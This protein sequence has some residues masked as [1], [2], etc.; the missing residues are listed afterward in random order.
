MAPLGSAGGFSG[1]RFWRIESPGGDYCLR[2]WPPADDDGRRGMTPERLRFIHAVLAHAAAQGLSFQLP[3]PLFAAAPTDA[4]RARDPGVAVHHSFVSFDTA[5]W[6]LTPW[7]PGEPSSS[8]GARRASATD[9]Q[10]RAALAALAELHLAMKDFPQA[11]PANGRSP[12]VALRIEEL[13]RLFGGEWLELNRRVE[14]AATIDDGG[15]QLQDIGACSKR[16]IE[17]FPR[18]APAIYEALKTMVDVAFPLQPCVR[19]IWSDH[20]LFLGDRVSGVIDFGA[21]QFE[22]PAADVA[23]LLGSMARG[24]AAGWRAGLDA[25]RRVAPLGPDEARLAQWFDR[26]GVLLGGLHWV[27]WIYQE[28]RTF[29]DYGAVARRLAALLVRLPSPR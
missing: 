10:L 3:V 19:D 29:D 27:R 22:T 18:V 26:C 15:R 9:V 5:L 24:D 6:E 25:Y 1:A 13:E 23:R 8:V 17:L 14:A 28:G 16:I 7:L 2:R 4:A 21:L 11:G 12:G 20:V